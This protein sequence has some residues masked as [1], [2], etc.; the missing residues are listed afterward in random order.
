MLQTTN[1]I[2]NL[3]VYEQ[4]TTEALLAWHRVRVANWLA[5]NGKEWANYVSLYNSG[6]HTSITDTGRGQKIS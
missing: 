6:V 2:F 3:T 1:S 4:V 5:A